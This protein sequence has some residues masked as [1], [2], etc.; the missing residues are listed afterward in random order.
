MNRF[1]DKNNNKQNK[2]LSSNYLVNEE[3]KSPQIQVIDQNGTNLGLISREQ[4]LEIADNVGLDLVQVG[5]KDSAP[6]A[7][8]LDFGKF[9]YIKK[10]QLS[11]AK[12]KQKLVQVKEIKLRPNIGD[13]DY[14]TKLNKAIKFLKEGKKVKFTIQFRGREL[15]MGKGL[16][17]NFFQRIYDDLTNSD[18]NR[19]I[20][21]EKESK[22]GPFWSKIFSLK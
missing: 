12:K 8:I 17:E 18:L 19:P 13:Q 21:E 1:R 2:T 5:Q 15:I 11:E 7:K 10:K 22:A 6:I 4:A 20:I 14:Q 9:L 3:I 16:G